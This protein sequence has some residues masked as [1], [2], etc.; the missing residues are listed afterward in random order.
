MLRIKQDIKIGGKQRYKQQTGRASITA[1][2]HKPRQQKPRKSIIEQILETPAEALSD[3]EDVPGD[4][5][6]ADE[7][8]P[9]LL[10][11]EDEQYE[12]RSIFDSPGEE[13]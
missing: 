4:E 12:Q 2:K 9:A 3:E 8:P 5:E 13:K 7:E 6:Y 10:S 11:D 1:R